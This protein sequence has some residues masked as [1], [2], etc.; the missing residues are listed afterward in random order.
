MAYPLGAMHELGEGARFLAM[1]ETTDATLLS[2]TVGYCFWGMVLH[3]MSGAAACSASAVNAAGNDILSI[4]AGANLSP[5]PVM[6]PI[7]I[8]V[9]GLVVSVSANTEA[10]FLVSDEMDI[11]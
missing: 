6:L 1:T 3:R 4:E 11:G 7:P 8:K 2:T 10:H 5:V 9:K